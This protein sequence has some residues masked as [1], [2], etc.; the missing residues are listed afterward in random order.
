MLSF[1][2]LRYEMRI[3]GKRVILLPILILVVFLLVAWSLHLLRRGDPS[4]VLSACLEIMLPLAVGMLVTM[5]VSDDPATELHLTLLSTYRGTV[6]SRTLLMV[7][8][9]C[10]GSRHCCAF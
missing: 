10:W 3:L 5:V 9:R 8:W 7:A 1:E 4:R 6:I 2:R